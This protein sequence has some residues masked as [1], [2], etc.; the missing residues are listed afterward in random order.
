[1]RLP[2]EY[3]QGNLRSVLEA[4][5]LWSDDSKN[6]FRMK[7]RVI[8]ER[9]VRRCGFESVAAHM[10]EG[11]TKLLNHIRKQHSRK[12]RSRTED[13]ITVVSTDICDALFWRL[14]VICDIDLEDMVALLKTS[15]QLCRNFLPCIF[16]IYSEY[17]L[18]Y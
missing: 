3:L 1:M 8:I 2:V 10:P 16:L 4:L 13:N 6:H 15:L 9:L 7:V 18:M 12:S 11:D 17:C 5:L 14:N